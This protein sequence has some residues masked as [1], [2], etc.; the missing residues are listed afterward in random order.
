[1]WHFRAL[2]A[3]S[4]GKATSRPILFRALL[5]GN[6]G[7]QHLC[8]SASWACFLGRFRR[9]KTR[10]PKLLDNT[11]PGLTFK[12]PKCSETV[13]SFT[14]CGFPSGLWFW[15]VLLG[16]SALRAAGRQS[17][18]GE[19]ARLSGRANHPAR[20][21]DCFNSPDGAFEC[22]SFGCWLPLLFVCVY[23]VCFS[24]P[25]GVLEA[26]AFRRCL[27]W[28]FPFFFVCFNSPDRVFEASA[29]VRCLPQ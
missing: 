18:T 20:A 17:S 29:F 16:N 6:G 28:L 2:A 26:S 21:P 12:A 14:L 3:P 25:D 15:E 7:A 24:S 1:M 10:R 23:F 27:P 19:R 5:S 11:P 8:P 22:S 9:S 4:L 13:H